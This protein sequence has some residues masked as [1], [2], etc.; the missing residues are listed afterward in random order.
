MYESVDQANL[1]NDARTAAYDDGYMKVYTGSRPANVAAGVSG[2]LLG[3]LTFGSTA[4]GS[5]SNRVATANTITQESSADNTGT[6]G[7][8]ACFDSSDT[9][10]SLHSAGISGSGAECIFNT[11]SVIA[12]QVITCTSFTISQPDGS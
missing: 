8:V 5:S 6:I 10:V 1:V 12:G 4:F 2:T 7:Y 3:I 11:L 9:L